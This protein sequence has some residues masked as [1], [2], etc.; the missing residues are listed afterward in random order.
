MTPSDTYLAYMGLAPK[1]IPHWEHWSNPDAETYLTGIDYYEHPRLCRLRMR[2]LYPE[3]G[4]SIPD[5]DTPLPRPSL[6]GEGASSITDPDGKRYVRWGAGTTSHW[7]WGERFH[8]V[9]E[10]LRY[11][12]LEHQ[13]MRE[14]EVVEKHDYTDEEKLYE[15][16]RTHFPKEWGDKAPEGSTASVGF[17]NTMFMWPLLTFGW[18]L[19]LEAC[20]HPEFKRIMDEFAEINRK[21]FRVFARLPVNFVICH[22]DIVT[23]RG[24]VCSPSWMR[25]YIFPRYEEFWGILRAAGK[26]VLFMSDGCLDAYVDDVMACGA[27]GIIS[28]PYTNYKTLAR[29][30]ENCFAAGEGDNRILCRNRPEEI[31]AMVESMV[32]TAK[33]TGG[34]MMCIGNHIPWNVPGEAVR[35]YLEYSRELAHR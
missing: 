21:V 9:E 16:Y 5:D 4:L 1:R 8:T 14:I 32:E 7:N 30:Y 2:E 10:V 31:R 27:R 22:D 33:M 23:S 34:Y 15:S 11:S 6:G 18:E 29:K 19:F 13:D 3:L 24:P 20:L 28:E 12:P 25:Q 35:L 17:Y 26:H